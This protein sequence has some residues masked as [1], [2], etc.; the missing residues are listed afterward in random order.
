MR[1]N[2][3]RLLVDGDVIY[4]AELSYDLYGLVPRMELGAPWV[5]TG[6]ATEPWKIRYDNVLAEFVEI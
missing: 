3:A 2:S 4:D 5:D 1:G 6:L